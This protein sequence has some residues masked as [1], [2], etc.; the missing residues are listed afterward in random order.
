MAVDLNQFKRELKDLLTKHDVSL[1]ISA[2]DCSDWY[3]ITGECFCVFDSKGNILENLDDS[4]HL[5]AS[6]L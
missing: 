2:D 5:D 4:I 3:G 6:D 1:G